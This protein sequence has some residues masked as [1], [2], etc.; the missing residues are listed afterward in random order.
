MRR[1]SCRP[2]RWSTM[3]LALVLLPCLTFT[4]AEDGSDGVDPFGPPEGPIPFPIINVSSSYDEDRFPTVHADDGSMRV[5]WNKGARDMFVYHVVQREHDGETLQE[6]EDWVSVEDPSDHDFVAHEHYSHEG[7][8]VTF[9]GKVHFLF[10][11]DDPTYTTGTEHDIV[12]RTLDPGTG[13]WG[14]FVE[15]TPNDAGQD[16]EPQAAVL[17]DRMVIAW[18]TNDAGKAAGTDDDIVLRTYDGAAF[19]DIVEVS[20]D[21]DGSMDARLDMAV[22]GDHLVMVWEW[23][24]Q[25]VGPSDWEVLYRE[26][27]GS[28]FTGDPVAIAPDARR[29]SKLPRVA[30]VQGRPFV[31]WENRP[32]TGEPGAVGILGMVMDGTVPHRQVNITRQGSGAENLQP[33]VVAAGDTAYVLWSSF[34]DALTHGP[35]SDIVMRSF[36]GEELGP[37]VEVSHPRDASDVNEGFVVGCVFQDNLYAVWRMMYYLDPPIPVSINEDIVMRRVTDYE[38][39]VR[40]DHIGASVVGDE[41]ELVVDVSTFFGRPVPASG[42][43]LRM[44]VQR[45]LEVLGTVGLTHNA[46]GTATASYT[47][48]KPG[49][50]VFTVTINGREVDHHVVDVGPEEDADDGV[51]PFVYYTVGALLLLVLAL[52]FSKRGRR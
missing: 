22:V 29:V 40:T 8:A 38:V 47:F 41:V 7:M 31:V 36:D 52:V 39:E 46:D 19:S 9:Q 48:E 3:L 34:D 12:L 32:P 21:G 20:P 27:D 23:N 25:D 51:S 15:V 42:L 11:S 28:A 43:D 33:D 16:R 6:G 26:W 30:Q 18:R 49:D 17:G 2:H 4:T 1:P 13:E 45:D 5:V 10:A 50:H 37:V 44:H 24:N 35:D 14:P